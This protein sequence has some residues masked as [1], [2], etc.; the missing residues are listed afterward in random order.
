MTAGMAMRW[1]AKAERREWRDGAKRACRKLWCVD[2]HAGMT[3]L[4]AET[5]MI[6]NVLAE[7]LSRTSKDDFNRQNF[8]TWLIVQAVSWHL[9]YLLSCRDL[10]SIFAERGFESK[11][12]V[13]FPIS[14][15][16]L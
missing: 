9:R 16:A 11:N 13:A 3:V 6:L 1:T 5:A 14:P 8:E 2:A 15:G 7:K 12:R 4:A 10:E